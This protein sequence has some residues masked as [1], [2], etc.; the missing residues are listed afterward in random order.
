MCST[1]HGL[2][3]TLVD[4]RSGSRIR[5]QS[6]CMALIV[7]VGVGRIGAYIGN[8]RELLCPL[9]LGLGLPI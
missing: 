8:G 4:E 3:I 6:E 9:A 1:K 5:N 7:V 2:L